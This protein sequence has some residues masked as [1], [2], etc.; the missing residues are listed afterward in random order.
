VRAIWLFFAVLL[1]ASDAS[2]VAVNTIGWSAS[3]SPSTD[4]KSTRRWTLGEGM[5]MKIHSGGNGTLLSPFAVDG[6][7]VWSGTFTSVQ[8]K[9]DGRLKRDNDPIGVVFGWR[10]ES[11][12]YRFGVQGIGGGSPDRG[13]STERGLWF[14]REQFGIDNV[15]LNVPTFRYDPY[16]DYSFVVGRIGDEIY[17]DFGLGGVSLYNYRVI[18]T[19]FTSGSIGIYSESTPPKFTNLDLSI[20]SDSPS[21][22][23]MAVVPLPATGPLAI[24]G[25]LLLLSASNRTALQGQRLGQRR[26]RNCRLENV[27]GQDQGARL[28]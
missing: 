24:A 1:I 21:L 16:M 23:S 28:R 17:F 11:N 15:I 25:L 26:L 27:P 10:D 12:H 2:A 4:Y 22:L 9:Y 19:S 5:A 3:V 7:F 13:S 8:Y 18:D 14:V 20:G 6:D